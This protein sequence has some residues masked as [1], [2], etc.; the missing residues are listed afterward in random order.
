MNSRLIIII[1]IVI[2]G[3][4]IAY[5]ISNSTENLADTVPTSQNPPDLSTE[6]RTPKTY[7]L[8]LRE[9]IALAANP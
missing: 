4:A 9:G 3:V 5:G 8:E 2:V 7:T 1:S 6:E